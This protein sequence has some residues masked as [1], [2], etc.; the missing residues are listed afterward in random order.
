MLFAWQ[1]CQHLSIITNFV[2]SDGWFIANTKI[3]AQFVVKCAMVVIVQVFSHHK[4]L[5]NDSQFVNQSTLTNE[6]QASSSMVSRWILQSNRSVSRSSSTKVYNI[7]MERRSDIARYCA[8]IG[9]K[10]AKPLEWDVLAEAVNK[11]NPQQAEIS[12]V[13]CQYVLILFSPVS[14]F[15]CLE[16]GLNNFL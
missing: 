7:S 3:M 14:S 5:G 10:E 13:E 1:H 9:A 6:T 15:L 12:A 2:A 4:Y 8:T 16:W 11:R